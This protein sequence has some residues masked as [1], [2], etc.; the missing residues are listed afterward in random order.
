MRKVFLAGLI[1]GLIGLVSLWAQVPRDTTLKVGQQAPTFFTKLL[2]NEDFFLSKI[3]GQKAPVEKRKPILLSFF[4]TSCVPCRVEIP[5]LEQLQKEF[6]NAAFYLVNISEEPEVVR[7]Y[8]AQMGYKLPVLLDKH[9]IIGNKYQV[10]MTPTNYIID[11][12]GKI[13]YI[14]RGFDETSLAAIRRALKKLLP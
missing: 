4:T 8:I 5:Q 13:V 6:P 9:G 11:A 10:K 3:V 2:T 1:L 14:G 12:S 7:R